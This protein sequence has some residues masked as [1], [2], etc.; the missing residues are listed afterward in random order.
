MNNHL[1]NPKTFVRKL[2]IPI[3]FTLISL[4]LIFKTRSPI[5]TDIQPWKDGIITFTISGN[6]PDHLIPVIKGAMN[7]WES[8]CNIRFVE[9]PEGEYKIEMWDKFALSESTYGSRKTKSG[10]LGLKIGKI[11]ES[12]FNYYNMVLLHELGH[13]L[14]MTHEQERSDRDKYVTIHWDNIIEPCKKSF[15][16]RHNGLIDESKFGYDVDSIMHYS[17]YFCAKNDNNTIDA[18]GVEIENI[19]ISEGDIKKIQSIYGGSVK[20]D[21]VGACFDG[22]RK[23]LS[24][25]RKFQCFGDRAVFFEGKSCDMVNLEH[26]FVKEKQNIRLYE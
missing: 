23:C 19:T 12:Y 25:V 22:Y 13:C 18:K 26:K 1:S 24:E 7:V 16:I 5:D 14:G 8:V 10:E 3:I 2:L 15:I 21:P 6:V 9:T 17:S 4:I 20:N 11:P